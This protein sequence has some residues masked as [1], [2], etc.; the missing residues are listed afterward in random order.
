MPV[1][2]QLLSLEPIKEEIKNKL[3]EKYETTTF[4][5]TNIIDVKLDIQEMIDQH[6]SSLNLETPRIYITAN[7]YL[8][9]RKL[10]DDTSTEI[11]WYGTVTKVPSLPNHYVIEDIIVYPQKVTGATCVQ[12][13][14]KMFEFEM[15]LSTEQVNSKRF[16][17]HSHVN[18]TTTPS[19]VDEQFYQDILT[20]TRD[21]FIILITNKSKSNYIRFY[22]IEHN[23][24]YNGLELYPITDDGVNVDTWYEDI[25]ELLTK[26]EVKLP[27]I[28]DS[29]KGDWETSYDRYKAKE[30]NKK[31]RG[32]PKKEKLGNPYDDYDDEFDYSYWDEEPIYDT[33]EELEEAY[34]KGKITLNKYWNEKAKLINSNLY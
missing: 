23:V 10:V 5:N 7:A 4:M 16:H 28:E 17:G 34:H 22:D 20:Q 33:L 27:T 1:T 32:R 15:S 2:K 3:I 30:Q 18:M 8:K 9:M 26:P 11:G 6:L 24:V 12:D 21:Y 29:V 14:D 13:D 19:G 31:K 25:E